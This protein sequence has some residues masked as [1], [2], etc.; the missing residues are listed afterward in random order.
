MDR[1]S[2]EAVVASG[3]R[4]QTAALL[5]ALEVGKHRDLVVEALC[6]SADPRSVEPLVELVLSEHAPTALRED[7]ASVLFSTGLVPA[8]APWL[9]TVW[10]H[11][12]ALRRSLLAHGVLDASYAERVLTALQSWGDHLG[13]PRPFDWDATSGLELMPTWR[14]LARHPDWAAR[15]HAMLQAWWS[16]PLEM[17]GPVLVALSDSDDRVVDA[18]ASAAEYYAGVETLVEL[19]RTRIR[20]S[21]AHTGAGDPLDGAVHAVSGVVRAASGTTAEAHVAR[22]VAPA[23]SLL[24]ALPGRDVAAPTPPNRR[25]AHLDPRLDGWLDDPDAPAVLLDRA[26][27]APSA[28]DDPRRWATRFATHADPMV[29][30]AGA[31][32]CG[33]W[34]DVDALLTLAGDEDATVRKAAVYWLRDVEPSAEAAAVAWKATRDARLSPTGR[35]EAVGTWFAHAED[36]AGLRELRGSRYLGVRCAAL[37]A[38]DTLSGVSPCWF[39][40][41][42]ESAAELEAW[43]WACIRTR[44]RIQ[45]PAETWDLDLASTQLLLVRGAAE[46]VWTPPV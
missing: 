40:G 4:S 16:E 29:R 7:A 5:A 14:W 35:S 19:T 27:R 17:V 13:R 23:S 44:H 12:G 20:W 18:A 22:W 26:L 11:G 43:L 38:L 8:G 36:L 2:L 24:R 1:A 30:V 42:A 31:R 6:A 41:P 39:P 45:P 46:G 28:V 3:D 32:W 9:E 21:A 33:A 34:A 15:E 37:A 10:N 25:P